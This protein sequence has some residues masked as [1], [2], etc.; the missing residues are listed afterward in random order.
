[1]IPLRE[2]LILALDVDTP[3]QVRELVD[4][5]GD[6]VDFYKLGLQLFLAGGYFEL[7][8]WLVHERG[9]KVFADLKLHDIPQTVHAAVRQLARREVSL[10]TVHA[11]G[12]GRMLEAA[13]SARGERLKVLA[14]TVLTSLGAEDLRQ[15]GFETDAQSLVVS[16]ARRAL[17]SGCDGVVASGVEGAALRQRL[18]D[19]FLI[20]MPGIR[21]GGAE[22]VSGDDQRRVVGVREAF[23][24]GADYI[25]VGRPIRQASDPRQRAEEVQRQVAEALSRPQGRR[26]GDQPGDQPG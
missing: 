12:G 21:P 6:A 23:A 20:V 7:I 3:A 17:A 25:V 22:V 4:R 1:M 13:S 24:N 8:D 16:R 18:G 2:R 5:L 10:T 11:E 9:K 19:G 26:G 15:L 14:V